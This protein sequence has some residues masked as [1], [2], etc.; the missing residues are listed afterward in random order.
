MEPVEP[1][2]R[3]YDLRH[4]VR[5]LRAPCRHLH[6]RPLTLHG[7]QPDHDRPPLRPPRPRRTC[8]R[9]QTPRRVHAPEFDPWTLVD[10]RWTPNQKNG[11]KPD[12]D[13]PKIAG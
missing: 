8:A 7:C 9:Q 4:T 10:A 2:R 3:V 13:T 12:N 6:L 11:V 5:D 1:V